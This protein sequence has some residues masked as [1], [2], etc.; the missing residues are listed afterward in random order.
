MDAAICSAEQARFLYRISHVSLISTAY[1]LY[2][3]HFDLACV[4]TAVYV[5]SITYWKKPEY[6][7]R[8]NLD[9][10]VVHAS[11][12]FQAARAYKKPSSQWYYGSLVL[13]AVCYAWG[14][15]LHRRRKPWASV[16]AHGLL[17][18]VANVGNW[19]LYS[20]L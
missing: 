14:I 3:G 16:Y 19:I 12:V 15:H 13:C 4:P 8:R 10:T 9:M 17:H 7:W 18:I 1:A 6:G 5:T 11:L 2:R 20:I